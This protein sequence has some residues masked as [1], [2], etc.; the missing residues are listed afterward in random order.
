[1][2]AR[3]EKRGTFYGRAACIRGSFAERDA[4]IK[5]FTS[6]KRLASVKREAFCVLP[7]VL[8]ALLLL[9]C[10][11]R[12]GQPV[13][14][15]PAERG[16]WWLTLRD[17]RLE[18]GA[19]PAART[20][21]D[22]AAVF[23]PWT[24]QSRVADLLSWRGR[25]Y[26]AV[27]GHGLARLEP[28]P[29]AGVETFYDPIL[30]RH[31]TITR[32]LP[33]GDDL[34]CHLY[35]NTLLNDV[36]AEDLKVRGISLL[37][38]APDERSW[39][40]VALPFQADHPEWESVGLLPESE[41]RW[42]FEWKLAEQERTQFR[43][44]AYQPASRE[45]RDLTRS[46]YLL[47]WRFPGIEDGGLPAVPRRLLEAAREALDLRSAGGGAGSGAPAI[48]FTLREEGA[49]AMLRCEL[50]PPGYDTAEEPALLEVPVV[51]AGASYFALLP[52][53]TLLSIQRA[54]GRIGQDALPPLPDG[55]R[56]G[57][58]ALA[59]GR[60]VATWEERRFYE[61]GAAGIFIRDFAP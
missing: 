55:F 23:A 40:S 22:R 6:A 33:G 19:P 36:R 11:G 61:V 45:E 2:E 52:D 13:S 51:R 35:F 4:S 46:D 9:S 21:A 44:T 17:G 37:R 26:L 5:R 58:F 42:L 28:A 12:A 25:L 18:E 16:P 39:R 57:G 41:D 14:P 27:N 56:Y 34:L 1:M 43:Y 53:G 3:A 49:A 30:F 10:H 31:R 29:S 47:A 38:L 24:V 20:A 32:L 50:R 48:Q 15:A 59:G 7:A 8:A 54:G 60:L